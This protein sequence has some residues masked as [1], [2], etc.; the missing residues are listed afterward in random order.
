[1]RNESERPNSSSISWYRIWIIGVSLVLVVS[2]LVYQYIQYRIQYR[3]Q[4]QYNFHRPIEVTYEPWQVL[5]P[6]RA[7]DKPLKFEVV[8]EGTGP[9]VELGDLVQLT[10][11]WRS[12]TGED[13]R[14]GDS[15]WIWIGF[16]TKDETPFYGMNPRL[17]SALVGQ[18][19]RGKIKFLESTKE[20]YSDAGT[21]YINPFGNYSYYAGRKSGYSNNSMTIFTPVSS[22]YMD[23]YITKVFKGQLKY[24]TVHLYDGTWYESCRWWRGD[25]VGPYG[26]ETVKTP[27]ETWVDEARFDGVSADGKQ[28]TFQYGPVETPGLSRKMYSGSGSLKL[29]GD[30]V[31]SEWRNLPEGVQIK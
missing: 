24:R 23:V 11:W 21:V 18:R 3:I 30:W 13:Q 29:L 22:G 7:M 10:L 19:E 20:G 6:G 28:A 17:L 9:L 8:Q 27:R 16:R 14:F 26:C 15:W 5:D 31:S 1:M 25:G 12:A 4:Y 2:I